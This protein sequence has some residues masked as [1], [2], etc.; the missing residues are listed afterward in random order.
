MQNLNLF[1]AYIC[2]PTIIYIFRIFYFVLNIIKGKG[3][4][5]VISII[6]IAFGLLWNESI[7]WHKASITLRNPKMHSSIYMI[8]FSFLQNQ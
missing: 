4:M 8:R 3:E 2:I 6:I 1:W 5:D 7:I